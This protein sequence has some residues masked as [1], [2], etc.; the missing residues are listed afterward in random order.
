MIPALTWHKG[1]DRQGRVCYI[2][3]SPTYP[4]HHFSPISPDDRLGGCSWWGP[5]RY[6]AWFN[7]GYDDIREEGATANAAIRR[8]EKVLHARSIGI[9]GCDDISFVREE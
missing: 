7:I 9:F 1:R 3:R 8:L 5:R 2:L 4:K 6:R